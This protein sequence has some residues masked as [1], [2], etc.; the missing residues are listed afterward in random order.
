[1]TMRTYVWEGVLTDWTSGI[2]VVR[3]EYA[4]DARALA[5][6]A[7]KG[8]D[9]DFD[10]DYVK[11]CEVDWEGWHDTVLQDLVSAPSMVFEDNAPF[12]VFQYGGA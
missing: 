5:Y 7:I 1:M 11:A 10:T 8:E 4:S 2:I 6:K 3:A 12:V 9:A